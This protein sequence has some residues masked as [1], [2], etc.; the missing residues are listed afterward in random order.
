[1]NILQ[2]IQ[3]FFSSIGD[4]KIMFLPV[5]AILGTIGA[6]FYFL[7]DIVP[8]WLLVIGA[9]LI[10][11]GGA[12]FCYI[13]FIR[14]WQIRR[15][16]ET[17][18]AEG[19]E[20]EEEEPS[21]SDEEFRKEL[22]RKFDKGVADL[23]S[24]RK[25]PYKLPFY[26]VVGERDSGKSEAIRRSGIGFPAGLTDTD[27]GIGG[28]QILD[29]WITNKAVLLDL[30]GT[31]FFGRGGHSEAQ[32][33]KLLLKHIADFRPASPLNGIILT[34]SAEQLLADTDDD[35]NSKSARLVEHFENIHRALG[36]Q[37]P[38]F[39]M[40]TK[41]DRLCGFLEYFSDMK[42]GGNRDQIFG[43]ANGAPLEEPFSLDRFLSEIDG[44]YERLRQ[45]RDSMLQYSIESRSLGYKRRVQ[46]NHLYEFPRSFRYTAERLG[47][48]LERI[49]EPDSWYC[50]PFFLRGAFYT[51][52]IQRDAEL[53]PSLA[54]ALEKPLEE[55][56][57]ADARHTEDSY[58]LKE[59]LNDKVFCEG[60]L[61]TWKQDPR[62]QRKRARLRWVVAA[63]VVLALFTAYTVYKSYQWADEMGQMRDN[64]TAV[65][66]WLPDSDPIVA[67]SSG[68][69]YVYN[70]GL[71]V[72]LPGAEL[73]GTFAE[74]VTLGQLPR[75]MQ[76]DWTREVDTP[77]IFAPVSV[78]SRSMKAG[79]TDAYRSIFEYRY[80]IPAVAAA[81]DRI[82]AEEE[83]WTGAGTHALG[84]LLRIEAMLEGAPPDL[85]S[86]AR[87]L[88]INNFL[89]YAVEDN[90][91]FAE[92]ANS[93]N[94]YVRTL[95]DEAEGVQWPA[96]V[97]EAEGAV[98]RLQLAVD[99][100]IGQFKEAMDTYVTQGAAFTDLRDLLAALTEFRDAE[101]LLWKNARDRG[102]PDSVHVI[103][104]IL[105]TWRQDVRNLGEKKQVVD[106]TIARLFPDMEVDVARLCENERKR[107]H[108]Q[109]D[110][111]YFVLS[112]ELGNVKAAVEDEPA[113]H[114]E[115]VKNRLRTHKEETK[116]LVDRSVEQ[117]LSDFEAL[118]ADREYLK[119]TDY[120]DFRR[121]Q[122][123]T[124]V[125]GFL[126][127]S[128]Y[129][130]G[131]D[132]YDPFDYLLDLEALQGA[133]DESV[134]SIAA[135]DTNSD[136][137]D[138]GRDAAEAML[139]LIYRQQRFKVV[140]QIVEAL[141]INTDDFARL[142]SSRVEAQ[143]IERPEIPLTPSGDMEQF[144][145]G[146]NTEVVYDL[147]TLWS[148]MKEILGQEKLGKDA[149]P[150]A[151]R[152][153]R[154]F[155]EKNTVFNYYLT[156]YLNYWSRQVDQNTEMQQ[157]PNWKEFHGALEN[158]EVYNVNHK[159]R[160]LYETALYAVD[161]VPETHP[162]QT[163]AH[164]DLTQK[165]KGLTD[166]F[167]AECLR[168]VNVWKEIE[169]VD[170][171]AI[172]DILALSA[173][174]F[175]TQYLSLLD[176]NVN[177]ANFGFWNSVC[178]QAVR[179]LA[180]EGEHLARY[181]LVNLATRYRGF[182]LINDTATPPLTPEQ[183]DEA[184]EL[185]RHIQTKP[186]VENPE[187]LMAGER[188][189][190]PDVDKELDR[191]Q[192]R[193][194]IRT[195]YEREWFNQIVTVMDF[196]GGDEPLTTEVIVL[197]REIQ[198][199]RPPRFPAPQPTRKVYGMAPW[200]YRYMRI[201]GEAFNTE[202]TTQVVGQEGKSYPL[203]PTSDKLALHFYYT[204]ED[205]NPGVNRFARPSG[206]GGLEME[207]L[208]LV[209]LHMG[210][211]RVL[212]DGKTAA[213]PFRVVDNAEHKDSEY[214]YWLG[215]RF[216]KEIPDLKAWPS[217]HNWPHL[218]RMPRS[219]GEAYPGEPGD[220]EY[221]YPEAPLLPLARDADR[222]EPVQTNASMDR[223]SDKTEY[224]SEPVPDGAYDYDP[225]PQGTSSRA[226]GAPVPASERGREL[227]T[228]ESRRGAPAPPVSSRTPDRAQ[229]EPESYEDFIHAPAIE[230]GAAAP[231]RP[232]YSPEPPARPGQP[233]SGA[234]VRRLAPAPESGN[235]ASTET[236]RQQ[237]PQ[238]STSPAPQ[239]ERI[240]RPPAVV[241]A[242]ERPLYTTEVEFSTPRETQAGDAPPII[243]EPGPKAP[244]R[245]P[246]ADPYT[247]RTR[248]GTD[249]RGD[250]KKLDPAQQRQQERQVS[251]G[252]PARR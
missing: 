6:G 102:E 168:I 172:N 225:A 83:H 136:S 219:L 230:E 143:W 20:A 116:S 212:E 75:L 162:G 140:S 155:K 126:Q 189:G 187:S 27:Q 222:V 62:Y 214:F 88:E 47:M 233:A 159:L 154:E 248:S 223:P 252:R 147:L 82:L 95:Y 112:R 77:W 194:V 191:I 138:S 117:F 106:N 171:D 202:P 114:I 8:L 184:T 245:D 144:D 59:V 145:D 41:A 165:M 42:E 109:V 170:R 149:L 236:P 175:K 78:F 185:V 199:E 244:D 129:V 1:M 43:W 45:R 37:V 24:F 192:G 169:K 183:F 119:V 99:S 163:D 29:W 23:A 84:Q 158:L 4:I 38:V 31:H 64:W 160:M 51:S 243:G 94:G 203:A 174:K 93:F 178:T 36:A 215:F 57:A 44:I 110:D 85:G 164:L 237:A 201:N 198:V 228:G 81:E 80:V 135:F 213:V 182:P 9:L 12:I 120:Q 148:H 157:Y 107:V 232:D 11:A 40:V 209:V 238:P 205:L 32:A 235:S 200:V 65:E 72:D 53:D 210:D 153:Q 2:K 186:K 239:R 74:G 3:E 33:W 18:P 125:Y 15:K 197:P 22:K 92:D 46:V 127:D 104:V 28:T 226:A 50:D 103:D 25:D 91:Q 190:W 58:F 193:E 146:Y 100:G 139:R 180:D 113:A 21:I 30:P 216:N 206:V 10:L 122:L 121:Y 221:R 156:E 151:A 70:G 229:P 49:F 111:D 5:L 124:H 152:L 224:V 134:R 204:S 176:N 26:L 142:V 63:G 14:P 56:P 150:D 217:A 179:L 227:E 208:P 90:S 241:P 17:K 234:S 231:S 35:I 247:E 137:F 55:L 7:I 69:D 79:M 220:V 101:S 54:R 249:S 13:R 195:E 242:P 130:V 60:G 133:F 177:K 96:K 167:D 98:E 71:T 52:A 173:G 218:R 128:E 48:Y 161:I 87:K 196:I 73:P 19:E 118:R 68:I 240:P 181:Y 39:V 108:T 34:I 97:L 250:K 76:D 166:D 105:A 86:Q 211:T 123:R 188:T 61:V 246:V 67:E 115:E 132:G 16:A 251:R 141:P 66:N 207:W 89:A 131:E